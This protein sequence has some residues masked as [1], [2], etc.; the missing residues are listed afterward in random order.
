MSLESDI[1]KA[2]TD[3]VKRLDNPMPLICKVTSID[4]NAL[5]CYCEPVNGDADITDVRLMAQKSNG[6]LIIPKLNSIVCVT[7]I[8]DSNA[9]VSMF[10]EIDEIQLNGKNFDGLVKAQQLTNK[11]N[12]LEN[13]VNALITACGSQVVT[14]AP[15]GTFPLANFFTSVTPLT[16]TMQIDIE[17]IKVKQG[18][19]S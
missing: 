19:G 15:S 7:F 14:L 5:T 13:K 4:L 17:N 8:D 6:F 1:K 11:L 18:D 10:S 2:L 16:P 3:F 9:Y 12:A